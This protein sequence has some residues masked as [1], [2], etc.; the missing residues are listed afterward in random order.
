MFLLFYMCILCNQCFT[1]AWGEKMMRFRAETV[2]L[3]VME[4]EITVMLAQPRLGKPSEPSIISWGFKRNAFPRHAQQDVGSPNKPDNFI[5]FPGIV[6][7]VTL[8]L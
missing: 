8:I 1:D 5:F 6:C 2:F 7:D 3:G 4:V